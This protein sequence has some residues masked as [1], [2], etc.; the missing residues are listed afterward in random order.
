MKKTCL[1]KGLFKSTQNFSEYKP[2]ANLNKNQHLPQIFLPPP[3]IRGFLFLKFGQRG[4]HEKI[5]QK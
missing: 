5:L 2:G 4:G 1:S 3:K